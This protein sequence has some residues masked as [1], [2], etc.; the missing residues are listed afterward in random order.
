MFNELKAV[1]FHRFIAEA[2]HFLKLP[3]RI[4]VEERER[5]FFRIKS[6]QGQME[7]D[8]AVFAD[9]IE[10]DGLFTLCRH[11]ADDVNRFGFQVVKMR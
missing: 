1:F 5:W 10:H 7:H 4:D 8:R 6:L 9:G 11:F 3:S 2:N